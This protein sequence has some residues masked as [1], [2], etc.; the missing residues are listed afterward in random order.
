MIASHA[1]GPVDLETEDLGSG[2]MPCGIKVLPL[3]G[4]FG[5]V[6][7][8]VDD[9]LLIADWFHDPTTIGAG[10]TGSAVVEPGARRFDGL[11]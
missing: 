2:V 11:A 6:Q 1:T 5:E 3:L 4:D 9:G 10:N 7:V 8:G